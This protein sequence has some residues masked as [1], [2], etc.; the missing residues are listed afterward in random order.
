[1][2]ASSRSG[3]EVPFEIE[4][5]DQ[6]RTLVE[7]HAQSNDCAEE[8]RVLDCAGQ[9]VVPVGGRAEAQRQWSISRCWS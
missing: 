5:V 9:G 7:A 1:M 2:T 6:K 3:N 4:R 8:G